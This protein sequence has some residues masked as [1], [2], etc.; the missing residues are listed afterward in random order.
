MNLDEAKRKVLGW[1]KSPRA[2]MLTPAISHRRP[3]KFIAFYKGDQITDHLL[4]WIIELAT[5]GYITEAGKNLYLIPIKHYEQA[6][7]DQQAKADE[8]ARRRRKTEPGFKSGPASPS[9]KK[10]N[11][12]RLTRFLPKKT[13]G[14]RV[15]LCENR[16]LDPLTARLPR[17][18]I[19]NAGSRLQVPHKRN[20][21]CHFCEEVMPPKRRGA[22]YCGQACKQAAYRAREK[23]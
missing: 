17:T 11:C 15:T 12:I 2:G 9:I 19:H 13:S 6:C 10:W 7:R 18:A 4:D 14:N 21:R 20:A 8:Y 23:T 1:D 22:K 16:V 3:A 5:Y